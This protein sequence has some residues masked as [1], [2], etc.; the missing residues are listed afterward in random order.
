MFPNTQYRGDLG[1]LD[2]LRLV[3]LNRTEHKNLSYFFDCESEMETCVRR[4]IAIISSLASGQTENCE[5]WNAD[6][7]CS[8]QLLI[9]NCYV[10]A[11]G[12]TY[13]F[14]N[15]LIKIH[16]YV[17]RCVEYIAAVSFLDKRSIFNFSLRFRLSEEWIHLGNPLPVARIELCTL[18]GI[19]QS[20]NQFIH[21]QL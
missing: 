1:V 21:V 14:V 2:L 4:S 12:G 16:N 13:V 9:V 10:A 11:C 20:V 17:M 6:H 18:L 5:N 7:V 3:H 8:D 19:A 15:L